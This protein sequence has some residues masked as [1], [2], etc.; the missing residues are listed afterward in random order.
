MHRIYYVIFLLF[1]FVWSPASSQNIDGI[2]EIVTIQQE[3]ISRIEETVKKLIGSFETIS[4]S[5]NNAVKT[6]DVERQIYSINQK[7]TLLE[8]NLKNITNLSYDLDF[9]LKRIERHLELS[10]IQNV[11]K[12][13]NKEEKPNFTNDNNVDI[14]KQSLENKTDG[15]LGFIKDSNSVDNNKAGTE[16]KSV[17]INNAIDNK[18]LNKTNPEENYNVA[19]DFAVDLDFVNA[20]KAFKEFLVVHKDS[21][22]VADAQYWLGRVYFAQSK[23]EEAAIT[24]AEFNSVFPNDARFQ[25]TTLLIAESAVNFAPKNQLCDIL[26]Q[27]LEFMINPSEKFTNRINVLKNENQCNDG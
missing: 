8:N 27:S 5:N 12:K 14:S 19:L 15:V 22:K 26:K 21:N 7:L 11:N 10:S 20:E 4:N 24:F 23:F 1:P 16:E 25:E 9:A 2:K 18:I 3:K 13:E 17:S 6:E